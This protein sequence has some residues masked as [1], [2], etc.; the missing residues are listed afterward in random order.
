MQE[1]KHLNKGQRLGCGKIREI[2]AQMM[3]TKHGMH[4]SR[5]NGN[6]SLILLTKTYLCLIIFADANPD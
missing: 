3:S 1:Y 4:K 5:E 2:H 6:A